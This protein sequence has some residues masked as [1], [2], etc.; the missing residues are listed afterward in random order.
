MKYPKKESRKRSMT[1]SIVWRII[2]VMFL[3]MVTYF[4]TRSLIVT[5]L[6][7]VLHHGIFVFVY[8]LHERFWLKIGF[9]RNSKLKPYARVVTYEIILGNLI[10]GAITLIITGSL[11]TMTAITLTYICNKYWMYY[12][13]DWVWSKIGWESDDGKPIPLKITKEERKVSTVVYAYQVADLFHIGH[14]KALEQAKALGDYLIVG[15]L[16]DDATAEYKRQPIIPFAQRMEIVKHCDYVDEVVEQTNVDP[17]ENLKKIKPDIVVHG[18]DWGEDFLG[19]K[20][21]RSIG[22]KAIRTKYCNDQSS[23][24]IINTIRVRSWARP[25]TMRPKGVKC[26]TVK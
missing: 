5:S 18:D 7:T 19:A 6:V 24:N 15:I 14:L 25:H 16:T 9:L 23:S 17:T 11:H 2:G 4:F 26:V 12:A 21:M 1:R 10:L 13:Y 20:Y 3:A 22:K 8:Y